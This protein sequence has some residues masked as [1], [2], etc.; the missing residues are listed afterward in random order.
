MSLKKEIQSAIAMHSMWKARLDNCIETGEFDTPV[1]VVEMDNQ[2]YLGKWLYG[3]S[4]PSAIRQSEAYQTVKES[5]ARF[6]Q[7]A[8][9]VVELALEGNK[10][11]AYR[12]MSGNGEY[13]KATTD[14]VN[15]MMVWASN[16]E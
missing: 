8:A 9:K 1:H 16:L 6:H 13:T 5:H 10:E 12:L 14:L 2:C 11:E 4:I 15:K 7:V 3:E